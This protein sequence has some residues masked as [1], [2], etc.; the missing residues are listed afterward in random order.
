MATEK[1][2]RTIPTRRT[3]LAGAFAE[4]LGWSGSLSAS[5]VTTRR[6]SL[7]QLVEHCIDVL[8]AIDGDP[9]LE[10][11]GD[12]EPDFDN[13]ENGDLE[14]DDCRASLVNLAGVEDW[15]FGKRVAARPNEVRHI[16]L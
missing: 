2:T 6:E 12:F 8:N 14:Q 11:G 16:S 7:E 1:P 15:W 10:D 13:E 4:P 3:D 5:S 9:D